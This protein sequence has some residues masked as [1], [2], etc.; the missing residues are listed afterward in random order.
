[1]IKRKQRHYAVAEKAEIE[2]APEFTR[3]SR[4]ECTS[5]S[6]SVKLAEI[7]SEAIDS[8]AA[9]LAMRFACFYSRRHSNVARPLSCVIVSQN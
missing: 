1:M 7:H 3:S 8:S 9:S 2:V 6:A 4:S 5:L